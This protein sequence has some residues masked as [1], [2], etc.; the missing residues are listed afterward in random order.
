MG[1]AIVAYLMQVG[2]GLW[3]AVLRQQQRPRPEWMRP[4]HLGTGVAMVILVLL[5]LA[6]GIVGTLGHYGSLGHSPHL[7]VGITTVNLALLSAWSAAQISSEAAWARPFHISMNVALGVL[8][9]AVSLTGWNVVQKYL[10]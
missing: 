8:F 1:F 3:M 2:L 4:V 9:V 5:L 10:P 7:M 6:I